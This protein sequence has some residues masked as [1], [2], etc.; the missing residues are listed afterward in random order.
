MKRLTLLSLF[1]CLSLCA[2]TN[3]QILDREDSKP[4]ANVLIYFGDQN[5]TYS[6][7]GGRVIIPEEF[8]VDAITAVAHGYQQLTITKSAMEDNTIFLIKT[9]QL[10]PDVVVRKAKKEKIVKHKA[11]SNGGIFSGVGHL[12][13]IEYGVYLT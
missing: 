3:F 9:D 12:H 13:G 1:C 4:I 5:S 2:Q 8:T 11:R 7:G 10:L 6:D